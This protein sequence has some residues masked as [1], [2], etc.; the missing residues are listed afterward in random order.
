M[1]LFSQ[2]LPHFQCWDVLV[3]FLESCF[4][5][6]WLF[7]CCIVQA[8]ENQCNG[9]LFPIITYRSCSPFF[10]FTEEFSSQHTGSPTLFTSTTFF[11][12]FHQSTVSS[13]FPL[14]FHDVVSHNMNVPSNHR[15]YCTAC[16]CVSKPPF[17]L[18]SVQLCV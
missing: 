16:N 3:Y 14:Y 9:E 8:I 17:V 1:S 12:N 5:S 6:G 10:T 11:Q 15:F 13:S 18:Y 4:L 2:N 7:S